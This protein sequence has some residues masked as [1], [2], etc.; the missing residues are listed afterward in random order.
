MNDWCRFF[1]P[2]KIYPFKNTTAQCTTLKK[3]NLPRMSDILDVMISE[4]EDDEL[5]VSSTKSVLLQ[6]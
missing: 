6:I 5:D 4:T 1:F 2:R 3:L